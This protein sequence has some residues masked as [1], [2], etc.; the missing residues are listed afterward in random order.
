MTGQLVLSLFPGIA[1]LDRAFEEEDFCI[2]RGPDLLWGGDIRNFHPPAGVFDGVIG[3][4]PCQCFSRPV[5]IV[6]H[7][8]HRVGE[9]LIPEFERVVAEEVSA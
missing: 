3:G 9:T 2:V 7:H 1:L 5:H 6:R 4:P 8:G